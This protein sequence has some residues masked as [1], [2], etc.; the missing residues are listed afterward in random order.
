M[1]IRINGQ[2]DQFQVFK[3][4]I[5]RRF[6]ST[7]FPDSFLGIQPRLIRRK[8]VQAESRMSSE[9]V[10][11]RL[12]FVPA[13]SV[14]IKP[15]RVVAKSSIEMSQNLHE[16]LPVSSLCPNHAEA[17]QKRRHP[18]R[19]IKTLL[20]LARCR[21]AKRMSSLSPPPPQSGMQAEPCLILKN[22]RLP[23]PQ[24]L[25]FF[26]TPGEIA[27]PLPP[28]LEDMNNWLVLA[29]SPIDASISGPVALASSTRSAALSARQE[30][31]RPS[32]PGLSQTPEATGLNAAP[33]PGPSAVSGVT[34]A[35]ESACSS[36]RSIHPHLPPGSNDLS[37]YASGP[38]H[39]PSIQASV[40]RR[41]KE[42]PQSS[43]PAKRQE[44]PSQ[45]RPGFPGSPPD[46]EYRQVPCRQFSTNRPRM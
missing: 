9:K 3:P 21:D 45:K 10:V 6:V 20:V 4:T 41:S 2:P 35:Q 28:E 11:D 33:L 12:A 46:D 43:T 37:S 15:D 14:H 36:G 40:L 17:S 32:E 26:L 34:A 29:D 24:I 44:C 7:L 39:E 25:K 8:I 38:K 42:A 13:G 31:D 18:T 23:C 22:H 27:S 19:Q 5:R 30:S 1:D 16:P